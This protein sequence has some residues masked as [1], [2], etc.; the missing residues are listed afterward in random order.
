MKLI[1][2]GSLRVMA[3]MAVLFTSVAY[4]RAENETAA[5]SD[6]TEIREQEN[7][8]KKH[9]YVKIEISQPQ[10]NL[11]INIVEMILKPGTYKPENEN[12]LN[13]TS[14]DFIFYALNDGLMV[15]EK[16]IVS[17]PFKVDESKQTNTDSSS[18]LSNTKEVL[19]NF[20]YT[21][22]MTQMHILRVDKDGKEILVSN[23]PLEFN[24]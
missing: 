21:S 9:V 24:K 6:S 14:G 17:D 16:I 4:G 5:I 10:G 18:K 3:L 7:N 1:M 22:E 15:F 19:L 20:N 8:E 11:Y 2:N 12:I 23:F 13:A